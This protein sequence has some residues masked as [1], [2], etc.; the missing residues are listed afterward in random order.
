METHHRSNTVAKREGPQQIPSKYQLL[1]TTLHSPE[2]NTP[3]VRRRENVNISHG[4]CAVGVVHWNV[5]CVCA[6]LCIAA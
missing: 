6:I 2:D 5:K 4:K 1:P 3:H